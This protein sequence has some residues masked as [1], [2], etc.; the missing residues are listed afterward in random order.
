MTVKLAILAAIAAAV[1]L[2]GA[3]AA[4]SDEAPQRV[5]IVGHGTRA[6]P[7]NARF[8]LIPMK[9]GLLGRDSLTATVLLGSQRIV[10]RA[11]QEVFVFDSVV[12]T[13]E[14]RHGSLVIRSHIEM[15]DAGSGYSVG[16]SSWRVVRG[17]G[18][19]GQVAGGGRGGHAWLKSGPWS[20]RLEGFL[21]PR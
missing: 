5:V 3:A 15:V 12:Q 6:D 19:Y 14:G 16:T 7:G 9:A 10:R 8:T 1:A 4:D 21:T 18:A 11:G 13:L 17:T 20:G 2:T